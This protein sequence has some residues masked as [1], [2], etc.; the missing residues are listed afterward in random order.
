M[1]GR[2]LRHRGGGHAAPFR[3]LQPIDADQRHGVQ[4]WRTLMREPLGELDPA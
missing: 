2:P 1:V 4:Q 3:H